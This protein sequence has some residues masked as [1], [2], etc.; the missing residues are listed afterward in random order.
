MCED[1]RLFLFRFVYDNLYI[2]IERLTLN[3]AGRYTC[4][5]EN[6]AGRAETHFDIDITGREI[7]DTFAL[8]SGITQISITLI[9]VR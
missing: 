1:A 3:D 4:V 5:A 8:R 2:E 7:K 6:P 9:L